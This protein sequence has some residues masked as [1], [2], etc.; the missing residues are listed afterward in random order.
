MRQLPALPATP[1]DEVSS[2]DDKDKPPLRHRRR[3]IKSGMDRTGATTVLKKITW[4]HEVVYTSAGKPALYQ[5]MTVPQFD[6]RYLLIMDSKEADIR[7][8][9]ASHLKALMSD[10]QLYG[11]YTGCGSTS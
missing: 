4:P 7:V 10:A 9:M 6:H 8:Q 5:D 1:R 2:T 11:L 3:N